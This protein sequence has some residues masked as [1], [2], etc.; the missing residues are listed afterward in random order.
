MYPRKLFLDMDGGQPT[1][2][3]AC[4]KELGWSDLR[5]IYP[6]KCRSAGR[7]DPHKEATLFLPAGS[8]SDAHAAAA[9][10]LASAGQQTPCAPQG[11]LTGCACLLQTASRATSAVE[12]LPQ[13]SNHSMARFTLILHHRLPA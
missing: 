8:S 10:A 6:G 4:F 9:T 7:S 12:C 5:Q 2:R 1:W 13:G 11:R 3:C